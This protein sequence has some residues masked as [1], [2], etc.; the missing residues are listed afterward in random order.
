MDSPSSS[1]LSIASFSINVRALV[2]NPSNDALAFSKPCAVVSNCFRVSCAALSAESYALCSPEETLP[3]PS[4][5]LFA[6]EASCT[7]LKPVVLN[8]AAK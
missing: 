5:S 6:E 1:T 3:S 7:A 2:L 8:S 4:V